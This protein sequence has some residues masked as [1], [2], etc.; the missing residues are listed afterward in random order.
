MNCSSERKNL[1]IRDKSV[2]NTED[3]DN[4]HLNKIM[5]A[6]VLLPFMHLDEIF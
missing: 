3:L 2:E 1:K 4:N 5:G 6:N